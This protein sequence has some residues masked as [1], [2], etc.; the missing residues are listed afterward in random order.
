MRRKY[1]SLLLLPLAACATPQEQCVAAATQDLRV[2]DALI[3]ETR[4]NIQRGYGV[5][6]EIVPSNG[7]TYCFGNWGYNSGIN[8]CS[9]PGTTTVERAVTIDLDEERKKLRGLEQSRRDAVTRTE[10][11]LA[12]CEARFPAG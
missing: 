4:A 6:E 5:E 1:L 10:R 8:F 3:V 2:L 9:N 7:F 12:A 11:A